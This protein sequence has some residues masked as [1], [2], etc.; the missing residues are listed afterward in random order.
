MSLNRRELCLLLPAVFPLITEGQAPAPESALTSG[1][2]EFEHLPMHIANNN[3]Q[4]RNVM[5]GKLA[6]GEGIEVHETT[7]AA[8]GSPTPTTHHHKHSEM[9]LVREGNIQLTVNGKTY[10]LGPGSV[11][12]AASNEEHGLT[13]VGSVPATY[14][15]VAIGPGAELQT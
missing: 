10:Q 13:N 6:T 12:F 3:A 8:G 9:W 11:G 4:I 15:L 1:A 14:F 7:L 2:F 5:R